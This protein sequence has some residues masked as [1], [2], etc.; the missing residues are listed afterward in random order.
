MGASRRVWV[1]LNPVDFPAIFG[2]N[3]EQEENGQ[4]DLSSLRNTRL[5]TWWYNVNLC[6]TRVKQPARADPSAT[7]KQISACVS[8]IPQ[9]Q[10]NKGEPE[11]S[12]KRDVFMSLVQ[13]KI[14]NLDET[15]G[16]AR[17]V[18]MQ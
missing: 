12:L 9:L 4:I 16:N 2:N 5:T 13:L 7:V 1:R 18:P 10:F 15:C 8:V 3:K 14:T 11:C 17:P 6:G